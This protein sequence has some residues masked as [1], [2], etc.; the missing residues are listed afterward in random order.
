MND[1][2][3]TRDGMEELGILPEF[4]LSRKTEPRERVMSVRMEA[5]NSQALPSV[6]RDLGEPVVRLS[7][8]PQGL[9]IREAACEIPEAEENM[10]SGLA[11]TVKPERR[12]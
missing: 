9:G 1:S 5:E 6:S 12:R 10:M 11:Q 2:I 3:D 7:L 8:N 4:W